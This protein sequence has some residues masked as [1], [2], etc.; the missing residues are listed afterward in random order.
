MTTTPNHGDRNQR[1]SASPYVDRTLEQLLAEI[2]HELRC[3]RRDA[4][5]R[6]RQLRRQ[7]PFRV[8][9]GRAAGMALA[10]IGA[11]A[12]V[13]AGVLLLLGGAAVALQLVTLA[14]AAWGGAAAMVIFTTS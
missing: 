9:A 7:Q 3:R 2:E 8:R 6:R 11:V 10:A 5:A 1:L 4:R 14:A 12:F 13:A